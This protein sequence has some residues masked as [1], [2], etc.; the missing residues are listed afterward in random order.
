MHMFLWQAP[1]REN[2]ADNLV[3]HAGCIPMPE[4]LIEP[5]KARF[6][7]ETM[8]QAYGQSEVM[9][10]LHRADRGVPVKPGSLGQPQDG[11]LVTLLDENDQPVPTGEVGEF[12]VRPTETDTIFSGYWQ[13]PE[14]TLK[15]VTNL[16]YHTGDLGRRDE[17]GELYFV[18]RR[19][20]YIRYKGRS[21]SSFEAERAVA[22]HDA[23]AV[24]AA[25]G[26]TSAELESE[27]ELMVFV[28]LVPGESAEPEALARF[29]NENAPYF[30]V[31]RYIEIVD[32][33]PQTPTGRVQKFK[34]RER[35]IGPKT[36]DREQ[37]GFEVTR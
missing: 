9:G 15:S 14:A 18:D 17:D 16:W 6:G 36:W 7:I 28:T 22:A 11:V 31:P 21:L 34:L 5:F 4:P 25:I 29:V 30:F 19:S 2:D 1:E 27:A 8:D 13:N 24:A 35:G 37:A 26:I 12:C 23:V 33:L 32:E 20:D 3:R 10:M